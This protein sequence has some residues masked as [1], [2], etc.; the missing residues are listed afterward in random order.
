MLDTDPVYFIDLRQIPFNWR[1]LTEET[2]VCIANFACRHESTALQIPVPI[3]RDWQPK[4][5]CP[6][7]YPQS[8]DARF[9]SN[10]V[11]MPVAMKSL[12]ERHVIGIDSF[13]FD[14]SQSAT[15]FP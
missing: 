1:W 15:E 14:Q 4:D 7:R 5:E 2:S 10:G 6:C 3:A 13:T 9:P 11:E 8:C 12:T